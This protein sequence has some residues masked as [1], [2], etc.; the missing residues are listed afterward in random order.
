MGIAHR[1]DHGQMS[2]GGRFLA[3]GSC[4]DRGTSSVGG[5]INFLLSVL[6]LWI[7]MG[8]HFSHYRGF[9][10]FW[11]GVGGWTWPSGRCRTRHGRKKLRTSS[12]VNGR[13]LQYQLK[14]TLVD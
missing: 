4:V 7:A 3:V 6:L 14:G 2:G 9:V 10:S 8:L 1:V 5:V 13:R 12:Y 11:W